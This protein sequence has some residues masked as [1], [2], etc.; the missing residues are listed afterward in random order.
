MPLASRDVLASAFSLKREAHSAL[1]RFELLGPRRNR[2]CSLSVHH[3]FGGEL[4]FWTALSP[5][6]CS[7]L[8]EGLF[9][10]NHHA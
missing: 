5:L 3:G 4:T 8:R 1:S 7:H 10:T 9:S 2:V 6:R